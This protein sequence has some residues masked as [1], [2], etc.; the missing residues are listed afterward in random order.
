MTGPSVVNR[1]LNSRPLVAPSMLKCDF[2]NLHREVALLE[3]AGAQLLHFDVMDGHF[4]PNLSYGALVIERV[5][6]LTDLPF[7]AHLMI[8]EPDRYL[9]DYVNAGCNIITF[10]V[11]AVPDPI[12]LLRRIRESGAAAGLSLNPGTPIASIAPALSECDLVLVMSVQPGFGGQKFQP[13]AL[14]KIRQLRGMIHAK[15]LISVD[16]GIG[17][18]TIS[19]TASAGADVF[20]VGSALFESTDYRAAIDRLQSAAAGAAVP[21][22]SQTE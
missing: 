13:V 14:E 1:L 21:A 15:S 7:E 3:A 10:H 18:E 5:R 6:S 22:R 20:V 9:N 16:G 2:A 4:V 19:A 12:P 17:P 11:E 8:S